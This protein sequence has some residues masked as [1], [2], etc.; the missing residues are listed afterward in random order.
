MDG[1]L[2]IMLL[3]FLQLSDSV[4]VHMSE[5]Q[6]PQP[7]NTYTPAGI[8]AAG[9]THAL[10]DEFGRVM[11]VQQDDL[12]GALKKRGP[13]RRAR[14]AARQIREATAQFH[15]EQVGQAVEATNAAE[16][17]EY[18][19]G[20]LKRA[21]QAMRAVRGFSGKINEKASEYYLRLT[22]P[23]S[24]EKEKKWPKRVAATVGVGVLATGMVYALSKGL[25]LS[26]GGNAQPAHDTLTSLPP[27]P[28]ASEIGHEQLPDLISPPSVVSSP[29]HTETL[30]PG[31]TIWEHARANLPPGASDHAIRQES[32]AIMNASHIPTNAPAPDPL[33]AARHLPEG[34]VLTVPDD[35]Q[36]H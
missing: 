25:H 5:K 27:S 19:G 23:M 17:N 1:Y 18:T 21:R 12:G 10:G 6:I 7:E 8:V 35:A 2:S 36:K 3:L 24:E 15:Q 11:N 33:A 13:S 28:P 34:T 32:V 30:L 14:R 9:E 4:I 31:D 22:L 20:L 26:T 29:T 16:V